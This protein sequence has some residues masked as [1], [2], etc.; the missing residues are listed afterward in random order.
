[1]SVLLEPTT[2]GGRYDRQ[3]TLVIWIAAITLA[4]TSAIT[5]ARFRPSK[6]RTWRER[7]KLEKL[8]KIPMETHPEIVDFCPLS[9]NP[10]ETA[11]PRLS[12]SKWHGSN[13]PKF[14][15]SR[16]GKT[17][18]TG[19]NTLKSV[20][21]RWGWLPFDLLKPGCSN[22]GG[23]GA[24]WLSW[25]NPSWA[26]HYPKS[27]FRLLFRLTTYF[28]IV[29]GFFLRPSGKTLENKHKNNLTR[30]F[31]LLWFFSFTAVIVL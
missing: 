3:Q 22:L 12:K 8:E 13:T 31:D 9:P 26:W 16:W 5:I 27:H 25:S 18:H 20:P 24:L 2:F 17:S 14:V 15:A 21:S 1:M 11:Q 19:T 6:H 30:L 29:W 4:T 10:P 28:F 7:K 23:F